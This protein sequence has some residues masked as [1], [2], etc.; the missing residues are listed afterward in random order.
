MP[1]THA[2][3]LA[4]PTVKSGSTDVAV[5]KMQKFVS[6]ETLQLVQLGD[7][8]IREVRRLL[9]YG[10]ANQKFD[11]KNTETG[12]NTALTQQ[13]YNGH[14]AEAQHMAGAAVTYGA[15]TC[16]DQAAVAYIL[17]RERLDSS[18][19]ACFCYS[20][21]AHHC[22]AA[23]GVPNTDPA[24]KVVIV[25]SWPKYAQALLWQDHFCYPHVGIYRQKAGVGQ[26]GKLARAKAK[27]AGRNRYLDALG[28]LYWHFPPAQYNHKW[29]RKNEKPEIIVYHNDL[30]TF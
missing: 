12:P 27:Y 26:P 14:Y 5:S 21:S 6:A 23:I 13:A 3:D 29:G 1:W 4:K 15:G 22:F 10:A 19:T 16:Q 8:V 25:D 2:L 17:L 24:D 11:F 28:T 20:D 18:K 9:P 7:A 30:I